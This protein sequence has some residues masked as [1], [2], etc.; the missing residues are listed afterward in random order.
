MSEPLDGN[1]YL[2]PLYD[3]AVLG[4]IRADMLYQITSMDGNMDSFRSPLDPSLLDS[5]PS[6]SW[7]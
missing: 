7:M 2:T 1:D 3:Q 6:T 5:K 4:K